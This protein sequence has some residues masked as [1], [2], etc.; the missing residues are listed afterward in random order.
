MR[1]LPFI[2]V[3]MLVLG[4]LS[5]TPSFACGKG[6]CVQ[7]TP[8]LAGLITFAY[9]LKTCRDKNIS[10]ANLRRLICEREDCSDLAPLIDRLKKLASDPKLCKERCIKLQ[11]LMR[12][13]S[14]KDDCSSFIKNV[15]PLATAASSPLRRVELKKEL[16]K[17]KEASCAD[18]AR[19]KE[20]KLGMK[21]VMKHLCAEAKAEEKLPAKDFPVLMGILNQPIPVNLCDSKGN[22][23]LLYAAAKGNVPLTEALLAKGADKSYKNGQGCDASTCAKLSGQTQIVQLLEKASAKQ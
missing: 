7:A 19:L 20:F 5:G 22:S 2:L 14:K 18:P 17:L 21:D 13:I 12:L 8:D 10:F 15:E 6:D 9:H 23:L 1:S 4:A 11:E 3:G 16:Q